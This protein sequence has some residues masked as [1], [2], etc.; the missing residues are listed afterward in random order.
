M[1][2]AD[3][4]KLQLRPSVALVK[5][6][7]FLEFFKTNIRKKISISIDVENIIDILL[8]FDGSKTLSIIEKS[9]R[10]PTN[11]SSGFRDLL[12]WLVKNNIL[13]IKDKTYPEKLVSSNGR[14]LN[15]LEEYFTKT[16]EVINALYRL[17]D[18]CVML[19]GLGAVGTW[20]AASL[21]MNGIRNYI[22]VDPDIVEITNLHRQWGYTQD[23]VG[24][25]KVIAL[26]SSLQSMDKEI[27]IVSIID[28]LDNDFFHR[29]K[30]ILP[31]RPNLIINCADSPSVDATS[32]IIGRYSMPR[33][34]PHIIGGGY[35]LHL[36]LIGQIVIPGETA[37]LRC[38]EKTLGEWNHME[39]QGIRKLERPN[40]KIGSF[41]PLSCISSSIGALDA[42]KVLAGIPNYS[43]VNARTEFLSSKMDFQTTK[44]ERR[45][46]CDWCGIKGQYYQMEESGIG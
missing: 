21:V 6:P 17:K 2:F 42:F 7:D 41:T 3:S 39:L 30:S 27:S 36:T 13:I 8:Q 14:T 31:E 25:N 10:I 15:T 29:H 12:D 43:V 35:N 44:I 20:T 45:S 11:S 9:F 18:S 38:F 5:S 40:R 28:Q 33:E 19:I 34:I 23:D 26:S 22:L 24:K 32:N 46:D 37:C 16:S 4:D 1:I